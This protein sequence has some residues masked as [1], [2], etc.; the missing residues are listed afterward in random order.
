MNLT[1]NLHDTTG[2]WP[3]FCA[4]FWLAQIKR[5]AIQGPIESILIDQLCPLGLCDEASC[6]FDLAQ[7]IFDHRKISH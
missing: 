4:S 7:R 3:R 1:L 6:L 5:G 2:L